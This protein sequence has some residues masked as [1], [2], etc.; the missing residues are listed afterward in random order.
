[1]RIV[2][3]KLVEGGEI[4]RGLWDVL[5][6]NMRV[7]E[8]RTGDAMAMLD[9]GRVAEMAIGD[10]CDKYESE[11]VKNCL[12]IMLD[13]GEETM[14]ERISELPDGEYHYEQYC[15]N[16]GLSPE[17]MPIKSKMTI[18]GD[19]MTIDFTGTAL[20]DAGPMNAGIP[21]TQGG[22]FVILKSWLDP[23]TPV[24]GGSFRPVKF[25]IPEGSCLAAELPAAV[26]GCWQIYWQLQSSVIGLFA[27]VIPDEPGGEHYHGADHVYIGGYDSSR[28]RPFILYEYPEGGT[29]GTKDTD[30]V[31]GT[32]GYDGGDMASVY[33]AES[34][35]QRQ[36]LFIGGLEAQ[37]GG[38]SPGFRRSGFGVTRKVQILADESQLNVM[39]DRSVIP[40]WGAAGAYPG[41]LNSVTVIRDGVEI[42]TSPLPGKVKSFPLRAGD[43]VIMKGTSGGGVGDPLDREF[44]RVAKDVAEGYVLEERARDAY[45]VIFTNGKVDESR[46]LEFRRKN[47]GERVTVNLVSVAEDVFDDNG[48]RVCTLSPAAARLIGVEDGDMMEHIGSNAAPLRGWVCISED[49]NKSDLPVGPIGK[50]ILGVDDGGDVWIRKLETKAIGFNE[51]KS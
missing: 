48:C 12:D 16:G 14:R 15:D 18:E 38:E 3:V 41:S 23:K 7:Q 50:S 10:L 5:F 30:G 40:P 49:L 13:S 46:S 35:E 47:R 19:S 4:N 42:E 24:N 44:D 43:M 8:E 33:P 51:R 22:V 32:F 26:G 31:T 21:V 17:P 27:Q 6:A 28:G 36:P 11:T 37:Q 2:P 1:M 9:T 45:G 20:Q 29:P 25:V 39:A 34:V